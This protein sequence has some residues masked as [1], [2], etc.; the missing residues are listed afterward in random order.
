M[1]FSAGQEDAINAVLEIAER[2]EAGLTFITGKAGTGKSTVAREIRKKVKNHIM[3]AFTGL[4][5]VNVEG[6]T[7]HSFFG[8]RIGAHEL[9]T[10]KILRKDKLA[11]VKRLQLIML[12][13]LSMI[14]ADLLDAMDDSLRESLGVDEPFGGIPVVAFG[15]PWQ[16]EPV[17]SD[18]EREYFYSRGYRSPFFFDSSVLRNGFHSIELVDVFRQVGDPDFIGALNSLRKGD[19][20][21]LSFFNQR[22]QTPESTNGFVHLTF[23]KSKAFAVNNSRLRALTSES[24]TYQGQVDGPFKGELPTELALSLKVGAQVMVVKNI[25]D[26]SDKLVANGS[27]GKVHTLGDQSVLVELADGRLVDVK[28]EAW[29]QIKYSVVGAEIQA[30]VVAKFTQIPL[31]LAWAITVHKSQGQTL[32]KAVLELERS[33][34][35]HGQLYVALSRVKSLDGLFLARSLSTRDLI[36]SDHVVEWDASTFGSAV[37]A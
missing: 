10:P 29:E 7:I 32:E 4:A 6:E 19:R 20:R 37:T 17:L 36:I 8:F 5:A 15:D 31:Q 14:R 22:V 9:A 21:G 2:G 13:E 26:K 24:K 35:G 3:L 34:F 25:R 12:D 28:E 23:T 18:D 11:V 33:A 1:Q 30:E 27:I 16:L